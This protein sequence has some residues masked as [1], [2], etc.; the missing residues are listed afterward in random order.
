ME[1]RNNLIIG[2]HVPILK[3]S[4]MKSIQEPHLKSGITAFQLFTKNPRSLK[5]TTFDEPNAIQCMNYIKEHNLFLVSHASYIINS[6]TLDLL[7]LKVECCVNDLIY[8][9]KMGGYGTVF[10][11]G[12]SVSLFK[13]NATENMFSFI[14]KVI[15]KIQMIDCKSYYILETSAGQGTELLTQIE[16]MGI[17]FHRFTAEQRTNLK[18]C[19]DT[20][21][22][23]AAGY[24]LESED[25]V[26]IFIDLVETNIGWENVAVI[27]LNDSKKGVGC[28]VDRHENIGNGCIF[29]ERKDGLTYFLSHCK[30]HGIPMILETP[31]EPKEIYDVHQKEIDLINGLLQI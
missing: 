26:K 5:L 12:K 9:S 18:I 6:A 7:D 19:I 3:R 29:K 17:F 1:F 21:H 30:N 28:C 20:C 25:E 8:I 22:V 15:E 27:H 31:H 11:V 14:S 13:D 23:Y 16:E 2:Y 4:F 10:H 24:G